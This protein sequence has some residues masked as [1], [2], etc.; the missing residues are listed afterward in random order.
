MSGYFGR[1]RP[2]DFEIFGRNA[3]DGHV[4]IEFFDGDNTAIAVDGDL[5]VELALY[6]S[7]A[8]GATYD[9][10]STTP[11]IELV[12]GG[13]PYYRIQNLDASRFSVGSYRTIWY[14]KKDGNQITVYPFTIA[15]D[16]V[17]NR[18]TITA[19]LCTV[20]DHVYDPSGNEKVNLLI[21]AEVEIADEYYLT[22]LGD[23]ISSSTIV[24]TY[25]DS[26]GYWQLPLIPSSLYTVRN[27]EDG[28]VVTGVTPKYRFRFGDPM[29]EDA[30]LEV[31][32]QS[33]V[34]FSTL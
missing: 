18:V 7:T 19:G 21:E 28:T 14:A 5:Y 34:D 30:L 26:S 29:I 31:P 13:D 16:F 9:M 25:T 17:I 6:D 11:P 8:V 15:S 27:E 32:D 2:D 10:T 23:T 33:Q 12:S 1:D 4:E 3:A 24:S 20:F 22:Y